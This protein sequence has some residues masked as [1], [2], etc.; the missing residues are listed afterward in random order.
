MSDVEI[1]WWT[2]AFLGILFLVFYDLLCLIVLLFALGLLSVKFIFFTD[3]FLNYLI[4]LVVAIVFGGLAIRTKVGG[5]SIL[6]LCLL[7]S[8]MW[9]HGSSPDV[10][11]F[12][13]VLLVFV[14]PMLFVKLRGFGGPMSICFLGI[15][16]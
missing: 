1:I 11:I 10:L 13:G 3:D 7:L 8:S 2:A 14:M 16:N 15:K 5:A 12:G 9:I 4:R 6:S